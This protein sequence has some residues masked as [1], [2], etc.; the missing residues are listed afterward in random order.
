VNKK[1]SKYSEKGVG[2]YLSLGIGTD[3]GVL[4]SVGAGVAFSYRRYDGGIRLGLGAAF[5]PVAKY[6]A[7]DFPVNKKPVLSSNE[8]AAP[9][10]V[11]FVEQTA[12]GFQLLITFTPGFD[13]TVETPSAVKAK[14]E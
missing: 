8:S 6:L 4:N 2:P 13:T 14:V 7:P 3:G 5:R 12:V 10:S 1:W 11:Q 9:T